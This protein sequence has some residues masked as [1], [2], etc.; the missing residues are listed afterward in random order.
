MTSDDTL[1]LPVT[2]DRSPLR[3]L[4]VVKSEIARRTNVADT[5]SGRGTPDDNPKP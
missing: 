4:F 5:D 3:G 1:T 2:N